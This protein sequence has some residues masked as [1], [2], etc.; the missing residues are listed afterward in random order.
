MVA[1]FR[2]LS[3]GIYT[4]NSAEACRYVAHNAR[5]DVIVVEDD[6]Q[7]Q[8]ILAVRGQLPHLRAIVQYRGEPKQPQPGVFSVKLAEFCCWA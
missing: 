2:G 4:T 8:K 7:L 3:T 5:C 1:A 6:T